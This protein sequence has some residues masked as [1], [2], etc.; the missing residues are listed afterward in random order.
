MRAAVSLHTARMREFPWKLYIKAAD[1]V[2]ARAA[3]ITR[4]YKN[5]GRY[6]AIT[7][8]EYY[9]KPVERSIQS[10]PASF[11]FSFFFCK[12]RDDEENSPRWGHH[13]IWYGTALGNSAW[14]TCV[15]DTR[16]RGK[17]PRNFIPLLLLT[18][19]VDIVKHSEK[20]LLMCFYFHC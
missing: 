19:E 11:L 5:D 1:F 13:L 10:N 2:C 3:T 12:R 7:E 15:F 8:T 18:V 16:G 4:V 6:A 20:Q 14:E 17:A 9:V